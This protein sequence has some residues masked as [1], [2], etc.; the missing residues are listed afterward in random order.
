MAIQT[1]NIG[2]SANKGDGDPLRTA[3]KKINE[4][5]AELDTTN[6]IRDIKGSVFGDDSTLLVDGVNSLIPS[7]V[8]SGALPAI[9]GS[10]L[11]GVTTSVTET[12]PVVGAI[13][14][15]VKAD[16]SGNISA[17]VAGTDYLTTVAFAD[18]T[19]TPTTI[20]GYGITDAYTK[21]E[22]DSSISSVTA[23]HFDFNITGDD[24][25]V[26]TVTSGSTL[27]ITGGTAITTASDVDGN[28]TVTGVA[29]DF[30]FASLTS[31]PSTIAGYGIT[32]ALAL[33]TTASTALAGN[34]ALFDGDYGSLSNT[35][36]LF[37][38]VFASL[39]SK[40]STIAGYGI[41]DNTWANLGDKDT[42]TG[43]SEIALGKKAGETTQGNFAVAIGNLAGET[44]QGL[45]AVAVGYYTG[46][47]TQGASAVA[48]GDQAGET[49]QG[50]EAIAIGKQAGETDQGEDAIAIGDS[51]GETDQGAQAIAIGD[52]AG[53]TT[54]GQDAIAI[55]DSAGENTQ[56]LFG[57]AIGDEAGKL[58]QGESAIAIGKNAGLT[59]QAANSIVINATGTTL[60]NTTSDSMVVK[61]IR[62]ASGTHQLEYN[63]TTGE[64]TYDTLGAGGGLSDVVSDTTPQLGGALDLN[65]NNI[66]GNGS[67]NI[68]GGATVSGN[69]VAGTGTVGGLTFAG[70]QIAS[71]DSTQIS[72]QD[73]IEIAGGPILSSTTLTHTGTF[74]ISANTLNINAGSFGQ[75][76]IGTNQGTAPV[77]LGSSNNDTEVLCSGDLF[78]H[79]GIMHRHTSKTG[80]TGTVDHDMDD[81]HV[82]MHSSM[83][84]DFTANLTNSHIGINTQ[85][86][87][88]FLLTQ[89]DPAR[90]VTALQIGGAAQTI[91][92]AGNSTPSGTA[93]GY[94]IVLFRIFQTTTGNYT[95]LGQRISHGGV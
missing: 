76:N 69:L 17:A 54:Q 25:T 31:K 67:I 42:A 52:G 89:G 64:V 30:T 82:F 90:M 80:A 59:S 57:V 74:G 81:G 88:T 19:A 86:T 1:I 72:F 28:I 79:S 34:T 68:T 12:D 61:P 63:P 16:G 24:S 93:N 32:D 66:T 50:I 26:R 22:V 71:D 46:K 47:T 70:T 23:G 5:F 41:T 65:N 44:T 60:D 51:A 10:A 15:I 11:T 95:V 77:V 39:T 8:L 18:L 9:D 37:D 49:N 83:A 85:T 78:I 58:N 92:W 33:G 4:N 29:Q 2:S 84:A 3:F 7:S 35:P 55:G 94:D 21:A 53:F 43:P 48:L 75:V 73:N 91:R 6:T 45:G 87:V 13:T 38:G 14:G 36:T 20:A 62:N 40:P 27:Q 56:G